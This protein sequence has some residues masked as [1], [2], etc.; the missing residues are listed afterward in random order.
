MTP[1]DNTFKINGMQLIA[2][3]TVIMHEIANKL[4]L[5]AKSLA[6]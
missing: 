6:T 4:F 2:H 5:H 3:D 1:A